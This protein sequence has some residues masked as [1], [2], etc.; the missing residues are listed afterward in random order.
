MAVLGFRLYLVT[1]RQIARGPI[2][3]VVDECLGAG[4]RGVQLRE[5]DLPI[6]DLLALAEDLREGTRA[7]GAR[8]LINDR[9]DVA[10]SLGFAG[11]HLREDSVP[12]ALKSSQSFLHS[13]LQDS[14]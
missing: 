11:V 3:E 1:D 4:L 7:H 6:R 5:K 12:L 14:E 13:S 2:R 9:A 8:L 10:L